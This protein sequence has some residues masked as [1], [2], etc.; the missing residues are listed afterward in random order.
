MSAINVWCR[1]LITL[2]YCWPLNWPIISYWL[3]PILLPFVSGKVSHS[4]QCFWRRCLLLSSGFTF[5]SYPQGSLTPAIYRISLPNS[6]LLHNIV[7]PWEQWHWP[8][9]KPSMVPDYLV[10]LHCSSL[11][12]FFK[13]H[14]F[15]VMWVPSGTSC[16]GMAL[17][18]VA[19]DILSIVF[20]ISCLDF[21]SFIQGN[22]SSPSLI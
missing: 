18:K 11:N 10:R 8:C 1:F 20:T 4:F 5:F 19:K 15:F 9:S 13:V 3:S 21:P 17:K 7:E 6:R 2:K 16:L 14:S 12:C 22:D